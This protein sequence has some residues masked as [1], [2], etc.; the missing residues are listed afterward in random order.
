MWFIKCT[1]PT[2][3][4]ENG[5]WWYLHELHAGINNGEPTLAGIAHKKLFHSKK[6]AENA[7]ERLRTK[8]LIGWNIEV[9]ST[10]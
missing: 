7:A 4:G 1:P 10:I 9:M 3:P 6:W 8:F 2:N 5:C